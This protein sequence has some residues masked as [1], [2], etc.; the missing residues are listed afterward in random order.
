MVALPRPQLKPGQ[1]KR[2]H[3][4]SPDLHHSKFLMLL[5]AS[6]MFKELDDAAS[7]PSK[8]MQREKA[9]HNIIAE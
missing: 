2:V 1:S 6:M 3:R 4:I 7:S 5:P 8:S 9:G